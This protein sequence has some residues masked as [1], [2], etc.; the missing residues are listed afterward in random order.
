MGCS[1]WQ[2]LQGP[3]LEEEEAAKATQGACCT[4]LSYLRRQVQDWLC[5]E[6]EAVNKATR[7][8]ARRAKLTVLSKSPLAMP[9][10]A[11]RLIHRQI[12]NILF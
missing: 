9:L 6:Q 8:G 2:Q 7:S 12:G 10:H 4:G 11:S 3:G 1:G 5:P